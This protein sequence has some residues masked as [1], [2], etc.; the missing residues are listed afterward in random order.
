MLFFD[1]KKTHIVILVKIDQMYNALENQKFQRITKF[2]IVISYET[3]FMEGIVILVKVH[4]MYNILENRKFQR[5]AKFIMV[6]SY[7]TDFME[8]IVI[9]AKVYEMYN[10]LK[11]ASHCLLLK[12]EDGIS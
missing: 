10:I 12:D 9:L 5:I 4:E 2:I 7:E 3:D 1:Q 11:S 6:I 8:G